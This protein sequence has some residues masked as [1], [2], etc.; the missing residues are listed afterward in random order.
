MKVFFIKN[1]LI[2]L[3]SC[4]IIILSIG[5]FFKSFGTEEYQNISNELGIITTDYLN[6]RTGPGITFKSIDMLKKNE[7]VRIHGK[8]GDWYIIQNEKNLIGAAHSKFINEVSEEK[9]A[10]TNTEIIKDDLN[11][12]NNNNNN[13]NTNATTN[14]DNTTSILSSEEQELLNLINNERKANNLQ[15][16][17][18]DEELQNVAKL[19]AEDIVKN[20]YFSHI[21]PTYG[22]P[23]EMLKSYNIPYKTGSENIAGNSN[24][25][26]AFESLMGSE[27]HKNNILSNEYNYTGIAVVDSIAYG[28]IIVEFFIG[29]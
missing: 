1:K 20:N 8:I 15:E 5:V 29:R 22:T 24:V 6:L 4:I 12:N 11:E 23:Y 25:K 3:L 27:S 13:S 16:Y 21:S 2:L 9:T 18:I 14:N 28:K 19:K 17:Q 26:S 7:Y 10:V